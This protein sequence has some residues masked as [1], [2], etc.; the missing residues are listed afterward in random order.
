M[1]VQTLEDLVDLTLHEINGPVKQIKPSQSNS[2]NEQT[3]ED[4]SIDWRENKKNQ[5]HPKS[6]EPES[7]ES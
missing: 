2:E 5:N 1:E 3:Y 7:S 6:F 4:L